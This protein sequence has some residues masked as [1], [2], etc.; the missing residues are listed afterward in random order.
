MAKPTNLG[1]WATNG[2]TTVEPLLAEKQAG[3]LNAKKLPARWL[4]WWMNVAYLWFVWLDAFESTPHTWTA[5]QTLTKGIDLTNSSGALPLNV[6]AV[7]TGQLAGQ[8]F[9]VTE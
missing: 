6:T 1:I 9:G 3:W 5:L 8:F 2:G 7:G 4:N